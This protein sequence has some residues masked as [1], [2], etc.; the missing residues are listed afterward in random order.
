MHDVKYNMGNIKYL[1]IG[2]HQRMMANEH[3]TVGSNSDAK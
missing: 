1:V 3:T 2:R